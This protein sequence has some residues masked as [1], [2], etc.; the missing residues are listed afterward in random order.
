MGAATHERLQPAATHETLQPTVAQ[1]TLPATGA[2]GVSESV[3]VDT[4]V[5]TQTPLKPFPL[6]HFVIG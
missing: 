4:Q 2:M 1:E 6:F 5:M 3:V